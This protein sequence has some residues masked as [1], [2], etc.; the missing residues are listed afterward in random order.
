MIMTYK[1]L[2]RKDD[3]NPAEWFDMATKAPRVTRTAADPVNVRVRHGRLG[4]RRH[5]F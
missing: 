4:I 3:V 5:F 1:I 2:T